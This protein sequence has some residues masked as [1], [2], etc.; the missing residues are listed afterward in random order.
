V[1]IA[2]LVTEREMRESCAPRVERCCLQEYPWDLTFLDIQTA[3]RDLRLLITF[4]LT[5]ILF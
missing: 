1:R 3:Y 4:G 5:N 2:K